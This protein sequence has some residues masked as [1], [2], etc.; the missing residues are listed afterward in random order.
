MDDPVTGNGANDGED[1]NVS[2]RS[3][4]R[5]TDNGSGPCSYGSRG[6]VLDGYLPLKVSDV[7]H[8]TIEGM[9]PTLPRGRLSRS[10][11]WRLVRTTPGTEE[12][13]NGQEDNGRKTR[14]WRLTEKEMLIGRAEDLSDPRAAVDQPVETDGSGAS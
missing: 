4:A 7:W 2:R 13:K 11:D 12:Q 8:C 5:S 1:P 14:E 9:A 10:L 6:G 3:L